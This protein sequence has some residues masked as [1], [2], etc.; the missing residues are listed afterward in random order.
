MI[1]GY[2]QT[3]Q[4]SNLFS[5]QKWFEVSA[6]DIDKVEIEMTSTGK[7]KTDTRFAMYGLKTE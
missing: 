4:A 2:M 7:F 3:F 5:E 6:T 1:T